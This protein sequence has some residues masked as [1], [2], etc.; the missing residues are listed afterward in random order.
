MASVTSL[1]VHQPTSLRHAIEEGI[2][3]PNPPVSSY[4]W[5]VSTDSEANFD[6][7]DELLTTE[8]CVLWSRGGIFRKSFKFDLENEPI[9][10]AILTYFL[11]SSD[12]QHMPPEIG[13]PSKK[14]DDQSLLSRALVVFLKT[15]AHIFF[16]SGTSHVVHMP[17]EV[18]SACAAPVGVII[19]RKAKANNTV[20]VPLRLPKVPPNSFISSNSPV[21]ARNQKVTEF[22]TEGL[23]NPKVLPLRLSST[24]ENM[25]QQP[26]ESSESHWPRLVCLTDPLLEIGL[27][28]TQTDKPRPAG[29]RRSSV[30][31]IFL[32]ASEEIVHIEAIK[33]PFDSSAGEGRLNIAVT[34]NRETSMYSV[35]RL[36]YL[37]KE[38]PF[39][40][41]Q[42]DKAPKVS[43]RRSSMAPGLASGAVTPLHPAMR[44]SFGA[45]LPGKK[46]RKSVRIDEKDKIL[47]KTLDNALSALDPERGSD[48]TRRQSRRVS[49]LLARADLSASQDRSNF[50]EPPLHSGPSGRRVESQTSQRP[51]MSSGYGGPSFGGAL[52]QN[53]NVVSEADSLLEELRVDG[54]FG[55]FHTMGLE[56]HDFDGLTHEMLFTKVH[57]ITMDNANVRYST[58]SKPARSQSRVFVLVGPPTATDEQGRTLLLVGIQDPVDKRLQLLTLLVERRKDETP[59]KSNRSPPT[60][61]PDVNVTFAEVRRVQS[62]VDSCKVSDGEET[63]I[64]LSEDRSGRRELSLQSPWRPLTTVALPLLFVDNINSLGFVGSHRVNR[65]VR[66][67]VTGTQIDSICHPKYR[68]VIDLR[69]KD[70]KFHR[71]R[72]RLQPLSPSVRRTLATCRSV[73][74]SSHA[75]KMLVGWWHIMQWLQE[76]KDEGLDPPPTDL[77]WSSL[78]ILLLSSF[79]VLECSDEKSIRANSSAPP[80]LA[81][82]SNFEL[83]MM[84]ETPNSAACPPWMRKKGWSWL[85]DEGVLDTPQSPAEQDSGSGSFMAVHIGLAKRYMSSVGGLSAFGSEGYLPTAVSRDRESRNMAAWS[86]MLAMH[87]LVE[88]QKL[89]ILSPEEVSPGPSDLKA[90]LCQ[91]SRWLGWKGY[92]ALYALGMQVELEETR[93]S[94]PFVHT[95]IAQPPAIYCILT[96]IQSHLTTDNGSEFPTLLQVYTNA[97]RDFWTDSPRRDLWGSLT[98]RTLMFEK[99]F[100]LLKSTSNPFQMVVAM[101]DCGFTPQILETLPEAVLT[102]LQDVIYMCQPHPPTT[103]SKSLLA[104]VN[105]TDISAVLQPAKLGQALGSDINAPSHVAKWDFKM[106]CQHLDDLHDQVEETNETDRQAVVRSLFRDDRRLNEAQHLLS[107]TKPRVLRLDAKKDWTEP[108]YLERQKDLAATV[109]TSTLAIPAGRGLLYYAL[110]HPLLTQKY[111]IAGF[112]LTCIIK[113]ANNTVGVDKSLFTEEKMNWAFF[114]QGVAGGLA[115]SPNAKG[116]DTS[117]ILYN[118]PGQDLSNR[119]AG[120]LLALGLNGHLKSVAKWVAFKYLTPKHTMTSIGLL[121]GLAA[122]YIGTMDSLITRL[123]SVHVTRMLPPGAAELN[124]SKH[125]Q[126]TGIMGIGL[127][128]CNSQHRRMSEIMM[129]EIE[130]IEDGEEEDPLRDEGYRLAAGFSLGLINLGRGNDLKGLRDMR[131]TEKLLTIATSTKRVELAHVLDRSAAGAVV[132]IALI[133]MKSG[134]HIVARK[135]D[136]PNTIL[137][138]DYVR[139][140][141]LLLR[142]VAKNIIMW[143]EINPTFEWIQDALPAAYRPRSRLTNVSKL[144]SQD[145]PFFSILAGLCFALGLRFAGSANTKVRDLLVHYLEEF[146]RIVRTPAGNFDSEVAR[147]NARMCMDTVALSCATVMAGTGDLVVLRRLR[148]LHGRDDPNTTYGS[149]LAAHLAIGALFLGCGTAT[150]STSNLAIAALIISFYPLFPASVQ[151]NR[152]HLQAFRHFWVLATDPRCLVARDLVTGQPLNVPVLIELKPNSPTAVATVGNTTSS[153]T[154]RE[155]VSFRKQTP[156]LLPPLEDVRHV[157]T[158]ASSMGFWNITIDFESSP[159]IIE[160]FRK[161]QSVY[162]RRRPAHE[163]PFPATLR[164]LGGSDLAGMNLGARD[165]L[166]WLFTLDALKDLTHAERSL[167]L[168]RVGSGGGVGEGEGASTA[169]DARLVLRS[170]LE[171]WSRDRLLGLRFLFEWADRRSVLVDRPAEK[172]AATGLFGL[173]DD[174]GQDD[175][176]VAA[177]NN[178][179]ARKG[180]AKAV[181]K[182]P[183]AKKGKKKV[184]VQTNAEDT[185]AR[186]AKPEVAETDVGWWLKDSTIEELKGQAWLTGRAE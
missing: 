112:N 31:A 146:M 173:A 7:E 133:F 93:D 142:T 34:V 145:M 158:D 141:I 185:A 15:Q 48:V 74:P 123:L 5:E 181:A 81:P 90:V 82:K 147:G 160:D 152:S 130:F 102:P 124:L 166:E 139:P 33:I 183:E 26:I 65:E 62:V 23:G 20:L 111:H 50:A 54:D 56:D 6:C 161:N 80:R 137:Q 27:V 2:L 95:S 73:L 115:I 69:D 120:F 127:L 22:S 176:S 116:I 164:A 89:S 117:W 52:N 47:E 72:V 132:A 168:D 9:T 37:R 140:D 97:T 60:D 126:T 29:G 40:G 64:I 148:A 131:L 25:W 84:H 96:W 104:L 103:W 57:S 1:G 28:V 159:H 162:L 172:A 175:S 49:S 184:T 19:Q 4:T 163:S 179:R 129:S 35:W 32:N 59:G 105:R 92:E 157:S 91:L 8:T 149:H 68:G 143:D 88:E 138:F 135:I 110:R 71:I 58:S 151:D 24:L 79:L 170:G 75:E 125:T 30:G 42:K 55:G 39:I 134:D 108:E 153:S 10:Q 169:V 94:A 167:V 118:K 12:S 150:F 41:R 144:G 114:H 16:L 17:F 154:S 87:L 109:A 36:S 165:P 86:T 51:R 106:I 83:M 156:C 76:L 171:G 121:L 44:E 38:D 70:G 99:L 78:V 18:E 61:S 53:L 113:P 101:H 180:K 177:S 122:S 155:A 128:Y 13:Q 98:S 136:V 178:K 174:A 11:A 77:E 85:L 3:P 182:T 186:D 100:V 45:P 66:A 43:R 46:T 119:H 107:S 63:I 14:P 67:R 21:S